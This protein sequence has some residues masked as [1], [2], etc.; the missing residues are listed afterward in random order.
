MWCNGRKPTLRHGTVETFDNGFLLGAHACHPSIWATRR[1]RLCALWDKSACSMHRRKTIVSIWCT[2]LSAICLLWSR[3]SRHNHQAVIAGVMI[4]GCSL[5]V[6]STPSMSYGRGHSFKKRDC[7]LDW[8]YMASLLILFG[9]VSGNPYAF[10]IPFSW[11]CL[12]QPTES[13]K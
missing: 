5:V 1:A 9:T 7:G 12:L 2:W 10:F 6:S 8:D 13:S 11:K 3:L 4:W